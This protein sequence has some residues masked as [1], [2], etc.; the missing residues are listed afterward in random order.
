MKKI[1]FLIY[2]SVGLITN[3]QAET[4]IVVHTD[5][6]DRAVKAGAAEKVFYGY[7]LYSDKIHDWK[8]RSKVAKMNSLIQAYE[9]CLGEY[10]LCFFY[11]DSL[12]ANNLSPYNGA[13]SSRTSVLALKKANYNLDESITFT[14]K[15]EKSSPDEEL[16][17]IHTAF[18][19]GSN[20]C[21]I[22]SNKECVLSSI[23]LPNNQQSKVE[24]TFIPLTHKKGTNAILRCDGP[25]KL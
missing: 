18:W 24:F 5:M 9:Q 11:E 15:I 2:I 3:A 12:V 4:M 21:K 19:E 17:K 14:T 25:C 8:V 20:S 23:S 10:S 16:S 6:A 1:I 7:G 22:K 13:S